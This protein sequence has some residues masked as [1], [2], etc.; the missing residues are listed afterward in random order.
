MPA[1]AAERS[2]RARLGH[3]L[4]SIGNRRPWPSNGCARDCESGCCV[5]SLARP[6]SVLHDRSADFRSSP[7]GARHVSRPPL[8]PF[9][10]ETAS[11]KARLAED[12]WNSRDPQSVALAY[13]ED[14]RWRDT[15]HRGRAAF[16]AEE[17]HKAPAHRQHQRSADRRDRPQV[18]LAAGPPPGRPSRAQRVRALTPRPCHCRESG[19]P[20]ATR[21][22]CARAGAASHM[23]RRRGAGRALGERPPTLDTAWRLDSRVRGN[24]KVEG[25]WQDACLD[26]EGRPRSQR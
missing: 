23:L 10:P 21:P 1:R 15:N 22:R 17:S 20:G 14:N 6:R 18:P 9:T 24:D 11:Q 13:T 4:P 26:R 8:P 5:P 12:A 25:P 7:F 2:N 3:R 16:D 19:N